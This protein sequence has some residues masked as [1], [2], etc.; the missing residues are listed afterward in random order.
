M[1]VAVRL[2]DLRS[3][4][5]RGSGA[6]DCTPVVRHGNFCDRDF[7]ILGLWV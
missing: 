7:C 2:I 1:T 5:F 3:V 6:L 4:Q